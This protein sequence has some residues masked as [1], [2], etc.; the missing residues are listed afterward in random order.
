MASARGKR[1]QGRRSARLKEV[2]GTTYFDPVVREA[3]FERDGGVCQYCSATADCID[4]LVPVAAGGTTRIENLVSACRTC[5]SIKG[6]R[7]F[8]KALEAFVAGA[9]RVGRTV[10]SGWPPIWQQA[11]TKHPWSARP[12]SLVDVL[13]QRTP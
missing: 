2:D 4:H 13:E 3:V 1:N 5:N 10:A 7:R 9:L 11:H 6:S 12:V 8:P